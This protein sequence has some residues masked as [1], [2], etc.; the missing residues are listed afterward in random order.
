MTA[1]LIIV[2]VYFSI[3]I[4]GLIVYACYDIRSKRKLFDLEMTIRQMHNEKQLKEL[5]QILSKENKEDA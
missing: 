3:V 1:D 4:I 5:R 2:I